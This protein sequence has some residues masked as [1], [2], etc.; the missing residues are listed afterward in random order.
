MPEKWHR[1]PISHTRSRKRIEPPAWAS[2]GYAMAFQPAQ[3]GFEENLAI[4]Q[5]VAEFVSVSARDLEQ[6]FALALAQNGD[7]Q[8]Q[9]LRSDLE[10]HGSS[11]SVK[12]VSR[13][14]DFEAR[15]GGGGRCDL[16]PS[17]GRSPAQL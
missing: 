7:Y 17:R 6:Q 3:Q 10:F 13:D 1:R 5:R 16:R 2:G 15:P 9:F 8:I 12:T 14:T 4:L 11:L